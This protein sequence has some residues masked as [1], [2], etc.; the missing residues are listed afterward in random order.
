MGLV[1]RLDM[2][3]LASGVDALYLSGRAAIPPTLFEAVAQLQEEARN[4]RS[5]VAWLIGAHEI[6]VPPMGLGRYRF[7]FDHPNGVVGITESADLP[8]L[9]IQPRARFLH[10]VG[11]ERAVDWFRTLLEPVVGE[12]ALKVSRID[13]FTDTQGWEL[14]A[15]DRS[16][17]VS[18]SRATATYEDGGELSGFVFGKRK[19]GTA[20]ARIYD[21]SMEI[22]KT[23]HDWWKTKWGGA[24]QPE[25]RVL[26]VEFEAGRSL[27]RAFGLATPESVLAEVGAMW[28]YLTDE[29]LSFR[30][31]ATDTTKSRWPVATEWE[32]I[33]A[34]SL[35]DG[36]IGLERVY[37]GEA[38]GLMRRLKPLLRGCLSSAGAL[39]NAHSLEET[40]AGV[41]RVI[42][43]DEAESGITFGSRIQGKRRAL[44]LT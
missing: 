10:A 33:R 27:L 43:S 39:L 12:V 16:R 4:C 11:P 32:M 38:V 17:F 28:G 2:V 37:A 42:A 5:E 23:G 44:G 1:G 36:A 25:A 3:E 35:R 20:S 34:A 13:L 41:Q 7:R 24:Y 8:A 22:E 9:R 21:K 14:K 6:T 29:W 30:D 31:R 26:R 40:L 15:E 19:S 18:R